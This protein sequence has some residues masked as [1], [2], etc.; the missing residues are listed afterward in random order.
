MAINCSALPENL[1]ESELFGYEEGAFSG[2]SKGGKIGL[3]ELAHRGTLFLDEIGEMPLHL[4]A[5][6]LRVIEE[7][8]IMKIGGKDL[9]DI[10]V[11]IIAATNRK[12]L[13]MSLN[14]RGKDVLVLADHFMDK[15]NCTIVFS[16]D[17]ERKMVNYNWPGNIRELRN[18]IEYLS[19]LGKD[20]VDY[21]DIPIEFEHDAYEVLET[22]K[23]TEDMINKF[24]INEG[25]SLTLHN[26]ILTQMHKSFKKRENMSRTKLTKIAHE[27]NLFITEQEIRNGMS[28][29]NGYGF[30]ISGKGRKGSFITDAG[31]EMNDKITGFLGA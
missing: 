5:K 6:L 3:F 14:Q 25:R 10:D 28:K 31:I 21:D 13:Q 9:I 2:A 16:K 1:L 24:I 19:N 15:M 4:Q 11:R 27:D 7:K 22:S 17:A 30:I 23:V 12:L 26:F 29:L 8:K 18:V 20:I